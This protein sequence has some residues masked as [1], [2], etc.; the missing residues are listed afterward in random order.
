M[1]IGN[2][3]LSQ[4]GHFTNLDLSILFPAIRAF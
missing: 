4:S 3:H 2:E 1:K